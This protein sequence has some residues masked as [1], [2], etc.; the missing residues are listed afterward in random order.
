MSQDYNESEKMRPVADEVASPS[1]KVAYLDLFISLHFNKYPHKMK[2]FC[3]KSRTSVTIQN[4]VRQSNSVFFTKKSV[5]PEKALLTPVVVGSGRLRE[6]P[7][8]ILGRMNR[9]RSKE[10]VEYI[11]G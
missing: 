11:A 4:G 10:R 7:V 6:I 9:L 3:Y 2:I 8:I 1:N 5:K